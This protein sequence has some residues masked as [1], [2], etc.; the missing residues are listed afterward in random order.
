MRESYTVHQSNEIFELRSTSTNNKIT[1][2]EADKKY[3]WVSN[4]APNR[5]VNI[6]ETGRW[7]S[8]KDYNNDYVTLAPQKPLNIELT[9]LD[10]LRIDDSLFNTLETGTPFDKFISTEGG[11]LPGTNILA[12]GDPGIGKTSL[13]CDLLTSA[14][15]KDPSKKVLFISAEMNRMDMAR[16][17]KR[18]PQWGQLPILFLNDYEDNAKKVLEQTLNEG[19]DLVLTDSYTEVNDTVKEES[20]MS[21]GKTEKWFLSLMDKH[22]KAENVAKKYTTFVTIL[23]V[24]KSGQF[25]GSNKLK[26]MTSAMMHMKWDG[27]ENTGKRYMEFSKNRCGQVGKKLYF[28]LNN[29]VSFDES[30]FARDLINDQILEEEREQLNKEAESF[31]RLFG[32]SQDGIPEDLKTQVAELESVPSL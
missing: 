16:Y 26:H 23:Q 5:I 2:T 28:D 12:V 10:D 31:D 19:W 11:F 13:L 17:L 24:N 9:K 3:E 22:N 14:Q 21:R 30:R 32:F 4:L 6:T 15:T 7:T 27:N 20:N 18:F 8:N 29:G 1:L 25:T